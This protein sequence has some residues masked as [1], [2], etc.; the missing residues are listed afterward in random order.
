LKLKS[1]PYWQS[2]LDYSHFSSSL[3]LT[4]AERSI[5]RAPNYTR[6]ASVAL[7]V[8]PGSFSAIQ[9]QW[10]DATGS[11]MASFQGINASD[12]ASHIVV[13]SLLSHTGATHLLY[14]V[15][16]HNNIQSGCLSPLFPKD[17]MITAIC[18]DDDLAGHSDCSLSF[19]IYL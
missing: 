5:Y 4:V 14:G 7:T 6:P 19:R 17:T 10:E 18:G 11:D 12:K 8:D 13:R 15:L 3:A 9:V 1:R 16:F 2:D